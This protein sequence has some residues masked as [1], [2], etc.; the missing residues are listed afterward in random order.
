MPGGVAWGQK[1]PVKQ[2]G[3]YK[4]KVEVESE[5]QVLMHAH[6][7]TMSIFHVTYAHKML[8]ANC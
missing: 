4:T 5:S 2:G 8:T 6:T 7:V 3:S 1:D